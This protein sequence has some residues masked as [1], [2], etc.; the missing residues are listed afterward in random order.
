MPAPAV[1]P[2]PVAGP[3]LQKPFLEGPLASAMRI[4]VTGAANPHGAAVCRALADKGHTVRAFGIAPGED[5]FH[6][7]QVEAFPG[8]LAIGGS[9]EPVAA[10]CQALVHCAAFDAPASD[11]AAHAFHVER[12]TLYARYAAE[13]ELVSQFVAVLPSSAPRGLGDAVHQA[14]AHVKGTRKLVPHVLLYVATPEEAVR[15]VLAS[16]A[17][18]PVPA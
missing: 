18:I 4:L 6:H 11:R 1:A 7:P 8:D 2:V 3:A 17:R 12:G 15:E 16:I 9:V 13:R 10:E 5:P 14:E